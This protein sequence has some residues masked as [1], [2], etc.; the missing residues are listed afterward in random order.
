MKTMTT[1]IL[2]LSLLC[3]MVMEVWGTSSG[4]RLELS[5]S[6]TGGSVA[7]FAGQNVHRRLVQEES[8]QQQNY[9]DAMRR[10]FLGTDEDL[11]AGACH[12]S[13]GCKYADLASDPAYTR[14]PS[15][16]TAVTALVTK[17]NRIFV[18]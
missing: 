1:K 16:C 5:Q 6:F 10:A 12:S 7:R 9:E 18:V 14:D 13:S 4:P 8:Y 17:D 15:G 2:I 11:L 3:T